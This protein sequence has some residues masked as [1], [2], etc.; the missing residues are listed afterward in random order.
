[1]RRQAQAAV[2]SRKGHASIVAARRG[3]NAPLRC[4]PTGRMA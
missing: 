1:L 3:G 2:E 4:A